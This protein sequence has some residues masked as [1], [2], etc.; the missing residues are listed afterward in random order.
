MSISY[1]HGSLVYKSHKIG[2]FQLTLPTSIQ[3]DHSAVPEGISG[4]YLKIRLISTCQLFHYPRRRG[5]KFE[6]VDL[7]RV[8]ET[9]MRDPLVAR[10]TMQS[11]YARDSIIVYIQGKK[12]EQKILEEEVPT[13]TK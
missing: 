4:G 13:R 2:K 10:S 5:I 8:E 9:S 11:K 12:L 1:W 3:Y 7:E 6:I